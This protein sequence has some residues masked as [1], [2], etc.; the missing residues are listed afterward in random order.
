MK[1][2]MQ[3]LPQE[4]KKMLSLVVLLSSYILG[5]VTSAL[6][7]ALLIMSNPGIHLYDAPSAVKIALYSLSYN[8]CS[9]VIL[10]D[11]T[12]LTHSVLE[13][14][15]RIFITALACM[16]KTVD[17]RCDMT[18]VLGISIAAAGALA[19]TFSKDGNNTSSLG[20]PCSLIRTFS[21]R[22]QSA[23]QF[24]KVILH[25][26]TLSIFVGTLILFTY[27]GLDKLGARFQSRNMAFASNN[28]K[29][30]PA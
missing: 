18:V 16:N 24:P 7:C 10:G 6:W 15:K 14:G 5:T 25:T 30:T 19:Y 20:E 1:G 11:V 9:H 22:K 2:I 3:S 13:V 23:R 21:Q 4:D 17:A 28:L 8:T 27:M 12:V 26:L 29:I